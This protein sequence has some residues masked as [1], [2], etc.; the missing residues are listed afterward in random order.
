MMKRS[1]VSALLSAYAVEHACAF[2]GCG[3]AGI[4]TAQASPPARAALC[5]L[6][7]SASAQQGAAAAPLTTPVCVY[8]EH[9]VKTSKPGP[10]AQDITVED[11]TP[12]LNA[13]VQ[14]SGVREGTVTVVSRHT[15][16]A[17]TIN[18]WESRL[19]DDIRTWLLKIAPPDDRSAVPTPEGGVSYFH[20]GSVAR[21]LPRFTQSHIRTLS[22]SLSRARARAHTQTST[23]ARTARTSASAAST[24]GGTSARWT[25]RGAW[26]HGG[27]RSPSTRTA[28]CCP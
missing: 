7:G 17:I 4:A 14:S 21:P 11:L 24:T 23:S 12:T 1:F 2:A 8:E 28:T 19:V 3:A 6:R 25:V 18:E 26:P 5:A 27:P 13:L 20:N 15:T 9:V 22:L 10:P 16:T